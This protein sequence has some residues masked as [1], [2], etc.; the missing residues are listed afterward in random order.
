MADIFFEN[1]K[2]IVKK[3][4]NLTIILNQDTFSNFKPKGFQDSLKE[5]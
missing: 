3:Q 4:K 5:W 1:E 2:Q